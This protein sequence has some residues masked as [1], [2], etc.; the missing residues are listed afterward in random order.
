MH[1]VIALQACELLGP[2]RQQLQRLDSFQRLERWRDCVVQQ[3]LLGRAARLGARSSEPADRDEDCPA[4]V[5]QF[6]E[7]ERLLADG[8]R[9]MGAVGALRADVEPEKL[10]TGI[11]AALQGGYLLARVVRD[12]GPLT[13][14]LDMALSQVKSFCAEE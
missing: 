1:E 11:M 13:I 9:R 10:A 5:E 12:N 2:Y 4:M 3:D 6:E 8:L 14:A 7:W